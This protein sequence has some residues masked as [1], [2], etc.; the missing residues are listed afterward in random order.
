MTELNTRQRLPLAMLAF[1]AL[2]QCPREKLNQ[3]TASITLLVNAD[4]NVT[5]F[6]YLFTHLLS[7]QISD[8]LNPTDVLQEGN[9]TIQSTAIAVS[10]LIAVMAQAGHQSGD[11]AQLA[12]EAGMNVALPGCNIA[13][14]PV[15]AFAAALDPVWIAL[16]GLNPEGKQRLLEDWWQRCS[17]IMSSHWMKLTCCMRHVCHYAFRCLCYLVGRGSLRLSSCTNAD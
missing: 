8:F 4:E 13:Y 3:F 9:R 1:P 2:R 17:M 14:E 5:L 10:K 15:T 12:Y 6:E 7:A 11:D 16:N